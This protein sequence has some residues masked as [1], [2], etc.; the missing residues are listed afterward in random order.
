VSRKARKQITIDPALAEEVER[1]DEFNLSGFVN[2]CLEQHF[3]DGAATTAGKAAVRAE[4]ERLENQIQEAEQER[5]RLREQRQ[6]LEEDLD[7]MNDEP[8]LLDQAREKLANTPRDPDNPAIQNWS[9]K[10]GIP[11]EEL[12]DRLTREEPQPGT[13][14]R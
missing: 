4:I 3:A 1:R 11:A 7:D 9:G 5:E 2:A 6:R 14:D 10:L 12:C 13:E 8:A